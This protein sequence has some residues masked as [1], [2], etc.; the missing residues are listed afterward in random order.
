MSVSVDTH[1]IEKLKQ[2]EATLELLQNPESYTKLLAEVKQVLARYDTA[3]VKAST[4]EA[5]ERYLEEARKILAS[6]KEQAKVIDDEAKQRK[7]TFENEMAAKQAAVINA[8]H[9]ASRMQAK[10]LAEAADAELLL[11]DVKKAK[12][13]FA[14]L[15]DKTLKRINAVEKETEAKSREIERKLAAIQLAVA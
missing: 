13:E 2:L 14:E 7:S 5:A 15:Q 10:A 11:S 1:K 12:A 8:M 4:V 9:D 3:S 6:A